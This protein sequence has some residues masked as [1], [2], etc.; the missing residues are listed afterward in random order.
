MMAENCCY[1]RTELMI[2][3]M[4]RRGLLGELI[5]AEGGYVHDMRSG[6]FS[7][8]GRGI[9]RLPHAEKR[10]GDLYPTHGL[11]ILAQCMNINRGNQFARLVS[12]A[13]ARRASTCT[14]RKP[15]GPTARKPRNTMP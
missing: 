9:W 5:H 8:V 7:K 15:S 13:P 3:N 11:A 12:M 2:L 1:D 6:K 4:V 14:P 10:K